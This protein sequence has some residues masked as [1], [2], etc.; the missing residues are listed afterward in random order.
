MSQLFDKENLVIEH[1]RD[2]AH[3]DYVWV[4]LF[5]MGGY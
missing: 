5:Y 4:L 1:I 2:Y 3:L